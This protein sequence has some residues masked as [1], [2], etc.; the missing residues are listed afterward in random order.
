MYRDIDNVSVHVRGRPKQ[1]PP[2]APPVIHDSL[3]PHPSRVRMTHAVFSDCSIILSRLHSRIFPV[4]C[5]ECR[6]NDAELEI[7][8][9]QLRRTSHEKLRLDE[10]FQCA[11]PTA[12]S[13]LVKAC[14]NKYACRSLCSYASLLCTVRCVS[15]S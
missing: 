3:Y 7:K 14:S 4:I 1:V 12:V 13:K 2:P 8:V 5:D 11:Q 15:K 6:Q 10:R 9:E